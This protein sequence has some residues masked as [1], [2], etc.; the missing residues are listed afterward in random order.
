MVVTIQLRVNDTGTAGVAGI[1]ATGVVIGVGVAVG[2]GTGC[3]LVHPATRIVA[4][5]HI[6]RKDVRIF[7]CGLLICLH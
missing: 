5:T 6:R 1:V 3:G 2:C 7:I 4:I